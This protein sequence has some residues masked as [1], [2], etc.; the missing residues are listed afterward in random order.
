MPNNKKVISW[1]QPERWT[2]FDWVD[3]DG[4]NPIEKWLAGESGEVAW[5]LNSALKQAA[6]CQTPQEWLGFKRFIQGKKYKDE[7]LWEF[8]FSAN[9]RQYRLLGRFDGQMKA[10]FFCGCYHKGSVY[11]PQEAFETALRR[12]KALSEGKAK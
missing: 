10:V 12:A 1:P 6:K 11:T 7:R 9:R 8:E 5:T 2:F 3:L 4:T